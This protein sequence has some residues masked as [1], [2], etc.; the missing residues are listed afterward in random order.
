[1]CAAL[2]SNALAHASPLPLS[3]W[4]HTTFTAR[5]GA[6]LQ[7]HGVTQT[8]DGF[9]WLA[10][11]NGLVRFDGVSF[12]SMFDGKLAARSVFAIQA[13]SDGDLWL[14]FSP[15]GASRISHGKITNFGGDT[16][17]PGGVFA[18]ARDAQ[19]I[20][21]M[22]ATGGLARLVGGKW[23]RVPATVFPGKR[24]GDLI[25]AKDGTLYVDN[26]STR[27]V[28]YPGAARFEIVTVSPG[29]TAALVGLPAG[30][31]AP[32]AANDGSTM[33]DA[34][35][36]LWVADEEGLSRYRWPQGPKQPPEVESF[37]EKQGLTS[38]FVN[39]LLQDREGNVWAATNRGLD[40]FSIP[41]ITPVR[42]EGNIS[43]PAIAA[44]TH[45]D[46]W[47]GSNWEHPVHIDGDVTTRFERLGK[48][49]TMMTTESDGT[50]W[51]GNGDLTKMKD[52]KVVKVTLP[53]SLR[54]AGNRM[55]SLAV[56]NDGAVWL[57]VV[58]FGLYKYAAGSW[59]NNGGVAGLPQD[60]QPRRLVSATDGKL[61]M[62]YGG[63]RVFALHGNQL[64]RYDQRDGVDL[65]NVYS[66]FVGAHVWIGGDKG[67][68][69]LRSGRFTRVIGDDGQTFGGA[70]SLVETSG[71]ELWI[72]TTHG[73]Y[74]VA[75]VE[76]TKVLDDPA[77]AVRFERFDD[78]DG[79]DGLPSTTRPNPS[80]IEASDGQLWGTTDNGVFRVDPKHIR[81]N[82]VEVSPIIKSITIDGKVYLDPTMLEL[83]AK[84][85]SLLINFTAPMLSVPKHVRFRYRMTGVD[86]GW[87][88]ADSQRRVFYTNLSPGSYRFEAEARN[89]DGVASKTPAF[90]EFTIPP[91]FLQ[92]GWFKAL[93]GF[94]TLAL[95]Y[96]IYL[97]RV[98]YIRERM[99][100]R[101]QERERIARE[102]HDT[103]LQ[104]VQGLILKID[105]AAAVMDGP[106]SQKD[107]LNEAVDR[108][109]E[110]LLEGRERVAQLRDG[111]NNRYDLAEYLVRLAQDRNLAGDAQVDVHVKG[112]PVSVDVGTLNEIQAIA[113][114]MLT[115]AMQH[116]SAAS[117]EVTISFGRRH[118]LVRVE[119]DGVG[120]EP[121]LAAGGSRAGH[122]GLTGMRERARTLG[123]RFRV[124]RRLRGGT[125]AEL[126][127]SARRA[128]PD[129]N[130]H[131]PVS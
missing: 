61:W 98:R 70:A 104:S 30:F 55:Q 7:V 57:S 103:V 50:L 63:D 24:P 85:S 45:G 12:E 16:I 26:G 128:Y 13:Q 120:I 52:D 100:A 43:A 118:F 28:L 17:P 3:Q 75:R 60:S 14:G 2:L 114:E 83:P 44:G 90:V 127:V 9:L 66:M 27:Y 112:T 94:L 41:R 69:L 107:M 123:A 131:P 87:T 97:I 68:S 40:Q 4:Q 65:G 47:I 74:R 102:L 73:L 108:A 81:R 116:A 38:A 33:V 109:Q 119:D 37:T 5:D 72:H 101:Q 31:P 84:T 121:S 46:V 36:S 32:A 99:K 49:T 10:T 59:Q 130:R 91:T 96:L 34:D 77:H 8:P 64:R 56:T 42:L 78:L 23:E 62:A 115:N 129:T 19:G 89:E 39:E 22:A 25:A 54:E 126:S 76:L 111:A 106:S 53:P 88:D 82:E 93:I 58:A 125:I 67:I 122:W 80:L 117:I 92:S 20:L 6:P 86:S 18:F 29:S 48:Y 51:L 11:S 21:W 105:T 15:G 110:V 124:S 79:I 113:G 1:V 71:G 95:L 35:G